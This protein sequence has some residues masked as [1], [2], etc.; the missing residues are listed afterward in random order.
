MNEKT[1]SISDNS[2]KH[3]FLSDT[4][5]SEADN[6]KDKMVV[7]RN[8]MFL[9]FVSFLMSSSVSGNFFA[10]KL[11]KQLIPQKRVSNIT[12][13]KVE[14]TSITE[15][16][17]KCVSSKPCISTLF[18]INQGKCVL[19]DSFLTQ[20]QTFGETANE[21]SAKVIETRAKVGSLSCK[22]PESLK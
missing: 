12:I 9:S 15:C 2:I 11:L 7:T 16:N 20:V 8:F 22:R 6:L 19:L 14:A 4:Q 3:L 21:K 5:S 10:V 13:K 18:T 17:L 1:I